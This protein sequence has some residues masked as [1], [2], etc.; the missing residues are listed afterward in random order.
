M[1]M[2]REPKYRHEREKRAIGLADLDLESSVEM[3]YDRLSR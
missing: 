3:L 2:S 1:R